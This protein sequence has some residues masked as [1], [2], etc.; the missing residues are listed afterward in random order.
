MPHATCNMP[1]AT[2]NIQYYMP[3]NMQ[4]AMPCQVQDVSLSQNCCLRCVGLD[5]GD[6]TIVGR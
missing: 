1:Y 5:M 2:C 3:C 6:L 4:H